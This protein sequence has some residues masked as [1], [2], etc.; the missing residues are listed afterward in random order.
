M[1]MDNFNP[2]S[3]IKALQSYGIKPRGNA[4]GAPP[5]MVHYISIRME[6]RGGAKEGTPELYFTDSDGLLMQLQ[7]SKYCGGSGVLGN[8]CNTK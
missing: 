5:P 6:N 2:D 8:V 3:V 1:S 4:Q 7:D